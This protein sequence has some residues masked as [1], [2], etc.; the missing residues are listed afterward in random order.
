MT[1]LS[2]E[3][4]VI[5]SGRSAEIYK[6]LDSFPTQEY[7]IHSLSESGHF[8]LDNPQDYIKNVLRKG[9]V[10]EHHLQ[11]LIEIHAWPETVA[12]DIGAHIGCLTLAMSKRVGKKG[13]VFAFEPQPKLFRELVM[14][15]SLNGASN[16]EFFWCAVGKEIGEIELSPL[17]QENEGSSQL[18]GGTGKFV[19]LIPLDA[20]HLQNISFVKIDVEGMELQVLEGA[21]KTLQENRPVLVLEIMGGYEADTAPPLIQSKIEETKSFLTHLGFKVYRISNNDYLALPQ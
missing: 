18:W 11:T 20:F 16:I 14:N 2:K 7:E 19:D 5:H 21:Q 6:Y 17:S 12:I 3:K 9:I 8:Y 13:K 4:S 15:M 10:W 1:V